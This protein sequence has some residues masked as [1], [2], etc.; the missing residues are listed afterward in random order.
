[1]LRIV[2]VCHIL[3]LCTGLS[4][5]AQINIADITIKDTLD[6]NLKNLNRIPDHLINEGNFTFSY[7]GNYLYYIKTLDENE[8]KYAI[9]KSDADNKELGQFDISAHVQKFVQRT[10]DSGWG[11]GTKQVL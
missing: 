9:V 5:H 6:F 8:L 7:N 1:M 3:F 10:V 11:Q 2:S 4:L